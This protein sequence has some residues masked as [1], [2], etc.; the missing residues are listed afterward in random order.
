M[1]KESL[2]NDN[3]HIYTFYLNLLLL[4]SYIWNDEYSP[5]Y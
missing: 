5:C 4:H 1:D 3:T 2:T